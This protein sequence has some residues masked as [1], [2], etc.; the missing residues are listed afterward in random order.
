MNFTGAGERS[1]DENTIVLRSNT[2]AAQF[3]AW[4]DRLW[5]SIDDRWSTDRPDPESMVSGTSCR[6]GV[7]NDFDDLVDAA[8]PGC[9][10]PPHARSL[11]GCPAPPPSRPP[12][13]L[14]VGARATVSK[15]RQLLDAVV[16]APDDETPR[17][18]YADW[19][20]DHGEPQGS[21]IRSQCHLAGLEEHDP[22]WTAL[23]AR[24]ERMRRI[25]EARWIEPLAACL[26]SREVW[27]TTMREFRRGFVEHLESPYQA[28]DWQ[29]LSSLSRLT[30]LRTVALRP[31]GEAP[32]QVAS[33]LRS[34]AEAHVAGALVLYSGGS[35]RQDAF[36]E[37]A[38]E[39]AA[40][41]TSFGVRSATVPPRAVARIAQLLGAR[42]RSLTLGHTLVGDAGIVALA[43]YGLLAQVNHLDLRGNQFGRAGVEA[44]VSKWSDAP[45]ELHLRDNPAASPY[46]E[47]VLDWRPLRRLDLVG[48]VGDRAAI[49]QLLRSDSILDLRQLAL[50][51]SQP[52]HFDVDRATVLASRPFHRL[53]R[54]T[55]GRCRIEAAGMAALAASPALG[56]LV[57]FRAFGC[58]IGD[59]GVEAL[60]DSAHLTRLVR[61]DLHGNGL[62]DAALEALGE[63]PHLANIVRLE[64]GQNYDISEQGWRALIDADHFE[65]TYLGVIHGLKN[66]NPGLWATLEER[67]GADVVHQD[68]VRWPSPYPS[69]YPALDQP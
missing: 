36:D 15:E 3:G 56:T 22:S 40:T 35:L 50:A 49:D 51:P 26:P 12:P 2:H 23:Y 68:G 52:W 47:R 48:T 46:I 69:P 19:L 16:A 64:L 27:E 17:L 65:P 14:H 25:H 43:A 24:T 8:D 60:V 30:P 44:L 21:F 67:F 4:F 37:V 6:D 20:T 31:T 7:D 29:V 61:L 58:Q 41:F 5:D 33:A 59:R 39:V 63:W 34:A 66:A 62:T 38:P 54:L 45:V 10:R 55:L 42:L 18:V 57:N 32:D 53:T 11:A 9:R 1:N 28:M 13:A